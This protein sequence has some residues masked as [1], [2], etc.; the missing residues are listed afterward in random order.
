MH[1]DQP[2]P[3]VWQTECHS[4]S[5]IKLFGIHER[6]DTIG[7]RTACRLRWTS[8]TPHQPSSGPLR[9]VQP[10]QPDWRAGCAAGPSSGGYDVT[11]AT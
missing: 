10:T 5:W 7:E 9:H 1:I 8:S 2:L 4:A 6:L 3:T 11:S